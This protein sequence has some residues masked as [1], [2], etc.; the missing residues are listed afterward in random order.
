M[1][2]SETII[3][4]EKIISLLN[5]LEDWKL[6]LV[7]EDNPDINKLSK[8]DHA[9]LLECCFITLG[10]EEVTQKELDKSMMEIIVLCTLESFRRK[11]LVFLNKKGNYD[12]TS[13]GRQLYKELLKLKKKN[14]LENKGVKDE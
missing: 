14:A 13:L 12:K 8:K 1:K 2:K 6:D 11:G 4:Q 9:I 10:K 3:K 7:S 5:Y